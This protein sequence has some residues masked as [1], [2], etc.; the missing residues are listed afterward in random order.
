MNVTPPYAAALAIL[1]FALSVRTLRLR[2]RLRIP[3]GDGGNAEML[4]VMRVH[5]NFAEY[6][7]LTL[8]LLLALEWAGAPPILVHALCL[9]LLTGRCAHAFGVS[10]P[11]EDFRYRVFGMSLT[12]AAL[13][14]AAVSLLA[15]RALRLLG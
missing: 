14:G 8:L 5:S 6:V 7:P 10:K 11:R 13:V 9:C 1:F 12:F 3:I 15:L 4:R 2:R